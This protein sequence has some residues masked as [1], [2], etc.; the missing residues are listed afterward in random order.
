MKVNIEFSGGMELLF[1]KQK[2][3]ALEMVDGVLLSDVIE[4]LRVKHLKDK[5]ELFI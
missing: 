4:E 1:E 2:T 3:L 5:E